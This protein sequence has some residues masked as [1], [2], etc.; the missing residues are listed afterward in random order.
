MKLKRYRF[1]RARVACALAALGSSALLA[2][3]MLASP[4]AASV[5]QG[6]VPKQ[7]HRTAARLPHRSAHTADVY[8]SFTTH[9]TPVNTWLLNLDVGGASTSP[10][11]GVIDW[12]ANGGANQVWTFTRITDTPNTY[13]IINQN[14]NQCLTTDGI[15]GDQVVQEPCAGSQAQHWTTALSPDAVF[16][17]AA[18]KSVYS[19]LYIDVNSDSPWPGAFID[20]W[21]G[22]GGDNQRF[23]IG[24]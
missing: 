11:A 10:G 12:W 19:G 15:P 23:G 14:S 16:K 6:R 5:G 20:T 9:V 7:A 3:G 4:A 21:Y 24:L 1:F 8:G 22:N 13:E 2:G 17:A 18:I